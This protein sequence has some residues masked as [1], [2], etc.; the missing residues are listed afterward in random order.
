M[1]A[2]KYHIAGVVSVAPEMDD[3]MRRRV[4]PLVDTA[5]L[6]TKPL[7][8]LLKEAYRLGLSDAADVITERKAND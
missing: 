1:T 8:H 4:Q 6:Q 5:S 2:T 3:L 7:L